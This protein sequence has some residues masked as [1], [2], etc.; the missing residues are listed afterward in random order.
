MSWEAGL[1]GLLLAVGWF[2]WEELNKRE[3]AVKAARTVCRQ[4]GVQLLDDSVALKL[5]RPARDDQQRLRWRREYF[6]EYSDTGN[7]RLPGY[8]LLLG[9][10]V[11]HANLIVPASME[12][13]DE[14]A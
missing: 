5:L 4:A 12:N 10:Q 14:T 8:V 2:W 3:L 13:S 7:N 9:G 1:V 6:F 11:L